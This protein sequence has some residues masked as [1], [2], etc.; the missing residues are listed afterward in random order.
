VS[1]NDI[2]RQYLPWLSRKTGKVYRLLTE[3]EWEYAARAGTS[4]PFWWGSSISPDQ[5]NYLD[6]AGYAPGPGTVPVDGYAPNP[7][8]LYNVHGNVLEWVQD[9][10]NGSYY[11]A[12]VDGSAWM[13]GN[14]SQRML[15]GGF[16]KLLGASLRSANRDWSTASVRD[17]GLGFRVARTLAP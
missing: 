2:T 5:A 1:W 3:A 4:T 13:S 6:G 9:C 8:G 14:C 16:W 15:R 12:P 10:W 7:W 11:G 17:S